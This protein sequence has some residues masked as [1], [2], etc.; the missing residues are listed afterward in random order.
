[1]GYAEKRGTGDAAYWRGRYKISPGRYGTV[2]GPDGSVV[3]FTRKLGAK[4]AADAQE[5]EEG[6][7]ARQAAGDA[8]A[9]RATFTVYVS[10][11][12]AG[13][14][15]DPDTL[16]TYQS[17]ITC[18]LLAAF[19][20]RYLDEITR[21]DIDDWE[22]AQRAAGY[23]PRGI[24]NRRN[25]LAE[26]LADAVA[27]PAVTLTVSPA[28]RRRGRGR[29]AGPPAPDDDD[30][31]DEEEDSYDGKPI[32]TPLGALLIAERAAI[33]SGRDD[34]FTAVIL[35]Y[36]TG[37]RWGELAGLETRFAR[38]GKVRV[39]WQLRERGGFVR[40]RPKFGKTR[41]VD[42][43]PFL[44]RI[45]AGHIARTNP[46]PCPCHG[47][48]YMFSGLGR[49]REGRQP[50]TA[51]DVAR[52]AGVSQ[53]TV[54]AAL[55]RPGTVAAPTRARIERAI[56][57]SGYRGQD[58]ARP[59]HW[60]RS[61]FG[62]WVWTPAVSGW[63]PERKPMPRRPV[64]VAADPWPG[65]PVR[66]RG[67]VARADAC[68]VPIAEGMTPHGMRHS[69]KSL[70]AELRTPEVLSHDRLGHELPGIAGIYS[71]PTPPMVAELMAG[72]TGCWEKAL[73]ERLAMCPRSPVA[74]LDGLLAQRAAMAGRSF[75]PRIL[76]D[77]LRR[78]SLRAVLGL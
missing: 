1:V 32:T 19:G 13:L 7:A 10:G 55:N 4:R 3:K 6:T 75:S 11:W 76:P 59:P 47:R 74:V 60:Y 45:L 66:G 36:Y 14:G 27:D 49:S 63:Y 33:M 38:A 57:E 51:A 29:R 54:S 20:P 8:A 15:L 35:G 71:H 12:F 43:P 56:G 65:A 53:A 64:P 25:L 77:D 48:T 5:T 62:Q 58:T 9:G 50:V 46:Q 42:A 73:D 2:C 24:L 21:K 67:N 41:E 28:A 26:I 34:E 37:L 40:K 68:W 70:M 18:H 30:N 16:A 52:L 17:I 69:H 44:D 72:L 61:G 31:E 22:A 78:G 39:R 23:K